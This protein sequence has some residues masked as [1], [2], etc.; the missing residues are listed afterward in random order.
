MKRGRRSHDASSVDEASDSSSS[1]PPP[2]RHR[3]DR[4]GPLNRFGQLE[5]GAPLGIH[6]G[7]LNIEIPKI[8]DNRWVPEADGFVRDR[9]T[10]VVKPGQ[11]Q[12]LN[13]IYTRM[14]VESK[15]LS[16]EHRDSRFA[17]LV[18]GLTSQRIEDVLNDGAFENDILS[19]LQEHYETKI[20]ELAQAKTVASYLA[21]RDK[22]AALIETEEA[23]NMIF[24]KALVDKAE[25]W[26]EKQHLDFWLQLIPAG[27][28]W[29]HG[30]LW[31]FWMR[32]Q[33]RFL[34]EHV[35]GMTRETTPLA[36][37]VAQ[38]GI[39]IILAMD[40]QMALDHGNT[41]WSA[42]LPDTILG[43]EQL[44]TT[45][46][47]LRTMIENENAWEDIRDLLRLYIVLRDIAL[48]RGRSLRNWFDEELHYYLRNGI[49]ALPGFNGRMSPAALQR[50]VDFNAAPD[51]SREA[52]V[53]IRDLTATIF[54]PGYMDWYYQVQPF[55]AWNTYENDT[56]DALIDEEEDGPLNLIVSIDQ[57][58]QN[59]FFNSILSENAPVL[60]T[61]KREFLFIRAPS[62]Y[63]YDKL[64][65]C[66]ER[67]LSPVLA[68]ALIDLT[69]GLETDSPFRPMF[70][71]VRVLP[72][73]VQKKDDPAHPSDRLDTYRV[74]FGDN[75]KKDRLELGD[76]IDFVR[77][78]S[79][80]LRNGVQSD[81]TYKYGKWR[82]EDRRDNAGLA[83]VAQYAP[84]SIARY[85]QAAWTVLN[86]MPAMAPVL[87]EPPDPS[88]RK[89]S[90]G[91]NLR[92]IERFVLPA[93]GGGQITQAFARHVRDFGN[94]FVAYPAATTRGV[95]W[96]LPWRHDLEPETETWVMNE[97]TA[98]PPHYALR[99]IFYGAA[100][101]SMLERAWAKDM[102]GA[103]R[104]IQT[105]WTPLTA[106][107]LALHHVLLVHGGKYTVD[108]T[109]H[110]DSY[111]DVLRHTDVAIATQRKRDAEL[112]LRNAQAVDPMAQLRDGPYIPNASWRDLPEISG[113]RH[114]SAFFLAALN[115]VLDA[116]HL[117]FGLPGFTL[118]EL[119]NL[120]D[121]KLKHVAT[122]AAHWIAAFG[123]RQNID[124]PNRWKTKMDADHERKQKAEAI[125]KMKRALAPWVGIKSH[126]RSSMIP[127][128]SLPW[129][130]RG[131]F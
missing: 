17:V 124:F 50:A 8:R 119:T 64:C 69:A 31:P 74:L 12:P 82:T 88:T 48:P 67:F 25:H 46:A 43:L 116:V 35:F 109:A 112:E 87:S 19:A 29:M 20:K 118:D 103:F 120:D 2:K 86:E 24:R 42:S 52:V 47:D 22:I 39:E 30:L 7:Q 92:L 127:G 56:I 106:L 33:Y 1:P 126:A 4:V 115:D 95:K 63:E 26:L 34:H 99:D 104:V 6:E 59:E 123:A 9:N 45:R 49:T 98:R 36:S 117:D 130:A 79:N 90:E 41:L 65:T 58:G 108:R 18:A 129:A 85:Q 78:D 102:P 32:W 77:F 83:I 16:M 105:Q 38:K 97:I 84:A 27:T 89:G 91:T 66:L 128:T 55:I 73:L 62:L 60:S 5:G 131:F 121:P 54:E 37:D 125:Q 40:K 80:V 94:L 81:N 28:D 114:F 23:R 13:D 100:G 71:F 57:D 3:R 96:P 14:R 72:P 53:A 70:D 113:Q 101:G 76:W 93:L 44:E 21:D 10:G 110:I 61:E 111:K 122:A 11:E 51:D 75:I 68:N 107:A 15:K